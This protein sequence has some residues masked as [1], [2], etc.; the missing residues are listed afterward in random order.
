MRESF[1]HVVRPNDLQ[2]LNRTCNNT[3]D[4]HSNTCWKYLRKYNSQQ[5]LFQK[6]RNMWI[7]MI[8]KNH[9]AVSWGQIKHGAHNENI[10]RSIFT[11]NELTSQYL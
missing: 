7:H 1:N 3:T 11:N 8:N 5:P 4:R 6:G 9:R 10:L 2:E